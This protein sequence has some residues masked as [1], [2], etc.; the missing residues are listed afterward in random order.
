MLPRAFSVLFAEPWPA[1]LLLVADSVRHGFMGDALE[2]SSARAVD[3]NGP[4][5]R[6]TTRRSQLRAS[7][8]AHTPPRII[9]M[10]QN[11]AAED[12]EMCLEQ[13][14]KAKTMQAICRSGFR[15]RLQSVEITSYLPEVVPRLL[16]HYGP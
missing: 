15:L 14:K 10:K 2:H 1:A 11:T 3:R 4:R 6:D 8:M 16:L 13:C 5:A 9:E 12:E 7:S